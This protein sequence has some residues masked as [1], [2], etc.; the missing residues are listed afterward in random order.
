MDGNPAEVVVRSRQGVA[1]LDCQAMPRLP[2]GD[3]GIAWRDAT[4][5]SDAW[6]ASASRRALR[7]GM[8][9]WLGLAG[10]VGSVCFVAF[11]IVTGTAFLSLHDTVERKKHAGPFWLSVGVQALAVVVS[12]IAFAGFELGIWL[13]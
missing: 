6:L 3:Q 2:C 12:A 10:I 4:T 13:Q 5:L 11:Q 9:F 7:W 1:L 8:S